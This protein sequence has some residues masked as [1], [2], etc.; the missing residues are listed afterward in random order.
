M[1][2]ASTSNFRERQPASEQSLQARIAFTPRRSLQGVARPLLLIAVSVAFVCMSPAAHAASRPEATSQAY[3][4]GYSGH[5]LAV[6]KSARTYH[7]GPKGG[8]YYINRNGNKTYVDRS[9]CR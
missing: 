7:T 2:H 1:T 6:R 4:E 5:F 9:L 8:C 3:P